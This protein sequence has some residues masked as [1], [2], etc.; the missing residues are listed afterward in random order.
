MGW[1]SLP[2]RRELS[3]LLFS[4]TVFILAYNLD[5]TLSPHNAVFRRLGLVNSAIIGKDGR[6]PPGWRDGLENVIFGE[7]RWDEGHVAGDGAERSREKGT[8]RYGAQWLGLD[9]VGPVNGEVFGKT[10][11]DDVVV[12]WSDDVPTAVLVKHVPG[13]LCA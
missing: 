9:E 1:L 5:I 6:R 7:W 12:R 11:A 8:D 13:A 2:N 3:L 4:L 10:T